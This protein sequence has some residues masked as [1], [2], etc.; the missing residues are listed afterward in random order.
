[1]AGRASMGRP[2]CLA[3][4]V[5]CL[6]VATCLLRSGCDAAEPG[7]FHVNIGFSSK[8][9]VNI[10]REDIRV[11]VRIL[12]QKVAK[13]TVGSAD[14][15][16]YDS[17]AEIEQDLKAK[18]LDAVALTPEDFLEIGAGTPVEPVM[19]TATDK[20]HEVELL[21]LTRKDSGISSFQGL[22]NRTIAIPARIVQYGNMY[23]TWVETLSM[24]KGFQNMAS[25][26]SS[27]GETK[28]PSLSLMQVFFRKADACAVTSQVFELTSELNPQIGRE[29]KVI[30][31]FGKLAGGIIVFRPDLQED[32]KQKLL[33]ALR[34]IHEDQEGR[35]LFVMFQLSRLIPYRPEYLQA[36]E[37]FFAE[38]RRIKLRLAHR[39]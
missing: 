18:R 11:A 23:F 15:R 3:V 1:M 31:R 6:F 5:L 20:G 29:L 35:Q 8:A 26:F 10:P 27:V 21:L 36:T 4:L 22:K 32:R 28:T 37:A 14:S 38:H 19:V 16:I 9:F 34:T 33:Q 17:T 39:R 2:A 7:S 13:N 12:S 30:E 25:F 24:R